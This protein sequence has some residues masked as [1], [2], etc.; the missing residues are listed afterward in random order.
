MK[1]SIVFDSMLIASAQKAR[2]SKFDETVVN[3]RLS[4]TIS[5]RLNVSTYY[6][7]LYLTSD[8]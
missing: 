7:N 8:V 2:K 6:S 3:G 1:Q 5:F 4:A